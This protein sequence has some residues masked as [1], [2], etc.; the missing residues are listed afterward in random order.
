MEIQDNGGIAVAKLVSPT[1]MELGTIDLKRENG[2]HWGEFDLMAY[3]D[4]IYLI[5][6]KDGKNLFIKK[7]SKV[8]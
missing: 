6:V 3:P 5:Q 2:R 8:K 1:G 4:G 7:V